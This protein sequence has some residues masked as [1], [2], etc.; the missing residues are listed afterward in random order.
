MPQDKTIQPETIHN[1]CTYFPQLQAQEIQQ[2]QALAEMYKFW[3]QKVNLI[4]KYDI[5]HLYLRHLAHSLSVS[6]FI[7]FNNDE[8]I[9]DLGSGAGLPGIP[10]A[11]IYPKVT[12]TLID[13]KAKK[14]TIVQKI[15]QELKLSNVQAIWGRAETLVT[16]FDRVISRGVTNLEQLYTWANKLIKEPT[17]AHSLLCLKGGT[18]LINEIQ[19]FGQKVQLYPI[20]SIIPISYFAERYLVAYPPNSRENI[21]NYST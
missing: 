20:Y 21:I 1:L 3:N 6:N 9:L 16:K 14:I 5:P 12:F 4:S 8:H 2:L 19:Q 17:S 7:N 15:I 11:I 13:A 10:L 18:Q